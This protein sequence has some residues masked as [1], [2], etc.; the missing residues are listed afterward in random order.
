MW[1]DDTPAISLTEMRSRA[2][3]IQSEHGLDLIL[4]DY[5]QLMKSVQANGKQPENRTQ[6]VSL[7]QRTGP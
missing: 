3:R 6:E 2:R 5:M 1:I 4:V 7:L